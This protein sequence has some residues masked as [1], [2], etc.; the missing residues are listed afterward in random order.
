MNVDKTQQTEMLN[1]KSS[2]SPTQLFHNGTLSSKQQEV[3]KAQNEF[4]LQ[5]DAQIRENLPVPVSD[6]LAKLSSLMSGR[7]CSFRIT[8][9]HP[10]EIAKIISDLNNSNYFGLDMIET[11]II[12]LIQR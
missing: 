2:G 8:A 3:A 6:P 9:V 5:K 12:K 7:T 10:D 11:R 4:F 1:W